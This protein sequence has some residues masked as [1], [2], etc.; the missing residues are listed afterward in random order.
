MRIFEQIDVSTLRSWLNDGEVTVVDIR[1]EETFNDA[2]VPGA[3]CLYKE[4]V[5]S[6]IERTDKNKPLVCY[7]YHGISSQ[8]AAQYF[9]DRGFKKVYSMAGGYEKWRSLV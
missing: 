7:C 6:F 1:D 3:I 4:N 5:E 8:S 9:A 2:H